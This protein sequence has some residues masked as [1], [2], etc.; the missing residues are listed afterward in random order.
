MMSEPF[1]EA[2]NWSHIDAPFEVDE[3]SG[4]GLTQE[5]SD[6]VKPPR[7]KESAFSMECEVITHPLISGEQ[8]TDAYFSAFPI[9]RFSPDSSI[10]EP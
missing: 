2:G 6:L 10:L 3:W 8:G 9:P 7:V 5:P 1:V 4:S